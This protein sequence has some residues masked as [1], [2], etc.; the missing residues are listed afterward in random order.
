MSVISVTCEGG[1]YARIAEF[2][3]SFLKLDGKISVELEIVSADEIHAL[4]L[5]QRGVDRPT[6]VLSFPSLELSQGDYKPFTA[7]NFPFD[8]DPSSGCVCLGSIVICDS[9]A[10]AQAEE[11]GHSAERERGYLF[12]H[13]LLHL[14]G[15]D[16]IGDADRA[17]MRKAEESIL[18]LA[19]L[20]R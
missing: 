12:L 9:I 1:D 19:G 7:Q 18:S 13:G 2:T 15:Y 20:K 3:A 6:D 11:Y 17:K 8:Y 4:N 5:S 10:V 16:H 14:L